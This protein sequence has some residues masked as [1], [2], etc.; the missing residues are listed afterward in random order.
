MQNFYHKLC[1]HWKRLRPYDSWQLEEYP[2]LVAD[3]QLA[4]NARM[5]LRPAPRPFK[6]DKSALRA[7]HSASKD[8]QEESNP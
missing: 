4:E 1:T 3:E 5:R 8:L 2:H 7:S 6:A